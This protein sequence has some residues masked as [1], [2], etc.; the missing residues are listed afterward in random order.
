MLKRVAATNLY[1]LAA[2]AIALA[3]AGAWALADL[4]LGSDSRLVRLGALAALL[5]PAGIALAAACRASAKDRK[6]LERHL[7]RLGR[8]GEN[9]AVGPIGAAV[10][11]E[12]HPWHSLLAP[13]HA[14]L[15]ALH[16]QLGEANHERT[17]AE[18]RLR[19]VTAERD[20]LKE[21][22]AGLS[23]PVFVV[24]HFDELV[25]ANPSAQKLFD[26]P[27]VDAEATESR[28]LATL[29]RCEQLVEM[30]GEARRRKSPAQRSGELALEDREGHT[31]FYGATVRTM[32]SGGESGESS[33]GAGN[34]ASSQRVVAVLR[35]ISAQ[36]AIQ[37][38]NAEFVSAV[39]HEM[40][41]PLAGIKAYVELLAD[42]D[43]EDETTREEFLEVINGQAERLQ[44]LIDNLLN[45]ARI[46]AGVVKVDKQ[47]QSL[48][49]LLEEALHVVQPAAEQKKVALASD[50]SQMYLGVLV[51]RDMMLQAAINLLSN[52]VKYTPPGGRVTLRS[53]P[54]DN[55]V[56]FEVEDTGVGLSPEDAKRV[57]EKFYRVKKDSN[58]A[59]GTGLG[60][61][62]AKHIVEDVHGGGLTVESTLGQGSTF[63][64]TLPAAKKAA[65]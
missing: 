9:G 36:K 47:S 17:R 41:T 12:S 26:L 51:D 37:K 48:N 50:L 22:L 2:A 57:F 62:L 27:A 4:G 24:N 6:E 8:I 14:R 54:K 31:H 52:A 7:D 35:D 10:L 49:E 44:R 13:W 29:V 18:V 33:G 60:L 28:A 21:V 45:L 38:R 16:E 46:E 63:R 55:D 65:G 40:K 32:A 20:E 53:R 19:R 58:M 1:A 43:A 23:E 61:P 34:A 25:M 64:V 30:L 11:E 39:S 59:P 56:V 3:V 15:Q 5:V 42:G